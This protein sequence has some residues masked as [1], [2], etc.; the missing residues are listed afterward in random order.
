MVKRGQSMDKRGERREGSEEDKEVIMRSGEKGM[1]EGG[2]RGEVK[3]VGDKDEKKRCY[4]G[5]IR[6]GGRREEYE[7]GIKG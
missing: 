2:R 6:A 4:V 5:E 3:I 1:K 7:R